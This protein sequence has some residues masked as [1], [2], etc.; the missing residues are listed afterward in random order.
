M[1]TVLFDLDGT[2]TDPKIGITTCILYALNQLGY[3]LPET[4]QLLWCIGPPL[5]VSFTKLLQ[6]TDKVLIDRAITLY[7]DRFA[8]VGLFENALYPQIPETLNSIRTAGYQTYIA[9]S[10]PH[11]F[12]K[13]IIEHFDLNSLFDGIYGSELDGT[14]SDK[15]ELIR[16]IL[17]TENLIPAKTVMIGDR[18]HDAIGAKK[19]Q[20]LAIGVTYGYGTEEELKLHGVDLIANSPQEITQYLC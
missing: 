4:D 15:A 16:H 12:A 2:L 1:D 19:N 11:V 14:R 8:T 17:L 9:T 10:K 6:T 3:E 7:R 5:T 18:S 20:L 13:R